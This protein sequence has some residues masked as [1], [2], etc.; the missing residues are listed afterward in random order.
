MMTKSQHKKRINF[1]NFRSKK[2]VE[3]FSD[4]TNFINAADS[5]LSNTVVQKVGDVRAYLLNNR[6]FWHDH[7]SIQ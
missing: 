7:L 2:T 4:A 1:F 6:D 5:N 3:K